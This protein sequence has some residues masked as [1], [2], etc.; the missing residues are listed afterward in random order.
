MRRILHKYSTCLTYF[1]PITDS[2]FQTGNYYHN[3][4][5]DLT[6]IASAYDCQKKCQEHPTCHFWTYWDNGQGIMDTHC[7][8]KN[9][10]APQ[11]A[12]PCEPTFTCTRGPKVCQS[13]GR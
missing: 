9:G 13:K 2:C 6:N 4:I 11:D 1:F 3:D 10:N 8:R 12:R 7:Y 5:D